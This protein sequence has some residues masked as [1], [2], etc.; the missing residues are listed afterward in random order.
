MPTR[1]FFCE[2]TISPDRPTVVAVHGVDFTSSPRRAKAITIATGMLEDHDLYVSQV[3]RIATFF[4]F[5]QW[6][7]HPGEWVAAFDFPFGLPRELCETL[8]WPTR[9]RA[10]TQHVRKIGKEAFRTALNDV[11][12]ARPV[13]SKYIARRGD[14]AAGSSSPMKLVNPP[15]GLMFFE[16][17]PRLAEAGVCVMPCA[18]SN[19]RRIALE[20]Y[21]GFLARKITR[22]SYKK[23]GIEGRS[24]KRL[25]AREHIVENLSAFCVQTYGFD[26]A[27]NKAL[28]ESC[29]LDG[30]GDTLDAVLCCVQAA[31]AARHRAS[32]DLR[33]GIPDCADDFEG[34]IATVPH[35]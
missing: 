11:R 12:E 14:F 28:R 31:T 25:A 8:N 27:F 9:W 15:V 1:F 2:F 5:E 33:Y 17:A 26:V 10:L 19:D 32:G 22:E 23:D 21:P 34:W 20:G 7:Q 24:E 16:G 29:V 13:G 30:S 35:V 18:P 4:E 6:L 3:D